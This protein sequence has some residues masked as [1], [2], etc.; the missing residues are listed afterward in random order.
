MKRFLFSHFGLLSISP[1]G[2]NK[3]RSAWFGVEWSA[4]GHHQAG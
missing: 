2:A 4:R 3:P 1:H